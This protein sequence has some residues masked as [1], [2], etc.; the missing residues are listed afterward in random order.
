MIENEINDTQRIARRQRRVQGK[1]TTKQH[2]EENNDATKVVRRHQ[3]W[4]EKWEHKMKDPIAHELC[5]GHQSTIN[6]TDKGNKS[7][8]QFVLCG[9]SESE[10]RGLVRSE[11]R[12]CYAIMLKF[13]L[14][15]LGFRF[16]V[17]LCYFFNS[18]FIV[19]N[20]VIYYISQLYKLYYYY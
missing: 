10:R 6:N 9:E 12:G 7:C 17:Y 15:L 8:V 20:L 13:S 5:K 3:R 1:K 11:K 18:F 19:S 4:M 16:R 14:Y 2:D